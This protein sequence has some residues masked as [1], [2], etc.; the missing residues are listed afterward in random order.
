MHSRKVCEHG[1]TAGEALVHV[2]RAVWSLLEAY[3]F[4]TLVTLLVLYLVYVQFE[5]SINALLDSWYERSRKASAHAASV[6][7]QEQQ[8]SARERMQREYN[9]Q[10]AAKKLR[11]EQELAEKRQREIDE[12]EEHLRGLGM[13][14]LNEGPRPDSRPETLRRRPETELNPLFNSGSGS[15]Y[16]PARCTPRGG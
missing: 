2:G 1:A 6:S 12:H 9:E 5:G 8:R 15:S 16:R 13:R 14:R 10:V 3:G 11:D 4:Y 7:F